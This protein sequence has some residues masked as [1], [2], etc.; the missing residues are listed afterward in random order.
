M[1][2]MKTYFYYTITHKQLPHCYVGRTRDPK[3]RLSVHKVH[4]ATKDLPLYRTI[5]ENGHTMD[6]WDFTIVDTRRFATPEEASQHE[7]RLWIEYEADLNTYEPYGNYNRD[8]YQ[9]NRER[10][11]QRMRERYTK[12]KTEWKCPRKSSADLKKIALRKLVRTGVIPTPLTREKHG[13]TQDEI[14][15]ALQERQANQVE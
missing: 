11:S 12:T 8:Y 10:L 5:R 3:N 13:I 15:Q 2:A 6:D 1:E 7:R 4:C 9:R 14:D